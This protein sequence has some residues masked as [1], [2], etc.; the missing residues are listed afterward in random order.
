[1]RKRLAFPLVNGGPVTT[2]AN[3]LAQ[4]SHEPARPQDAH[5]RRDSICLICSFDG[6]LS[7]ANSLGTGRL[8]LLWIYASL[9]AAVPYV[10]ES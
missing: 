9:A 5:L 3:I 2:V 7:Q 1:M 4:A 6:I 10:G 8:G